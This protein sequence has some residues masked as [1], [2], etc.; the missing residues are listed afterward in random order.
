MQRRRIASLGADV[1]AAARSLWRRWDEDARPWLLGVL[2]LGL[3]FRALAA[4]SA[5]VS[6]D[7]PRTLLVARSLASG[8]GFRLCDLYFPACGPGHDLTAQV[9]PV[10][11]GVFAVV[12]RL[13]GEHLSLPLMVGIQMGLGILTVY[14]VFALGV[15]LFQ[16]TR[17]ALLAALLCATYP[18]LISYELYPREEPLFTAALVASTLLLVRALRDSAPVR[19]G[20]AGLGFG[21]ASLCRFALVYYP[22]ILTPGLLALTRGPGR[23]RAAV[24]LAF[25]ACFALVMLPWVWR[26]ERAFGAFVPG[27]TLSG[28]NLYRHNFI[29]GE[30]RPLHYVEGL[31]GDSAIRALLR[32]HPELTGRETEV[33]IDRLYRDEALTIIRAHP[34]RYLELSGRRLVALFTEYGVQPEGLP[35]SW[36]VV[37]AEH[38]LIVALA[39]ATLLRRRLS[40]PPALAAIALL[41]GYYVAG[42]ALA[43]ARLRYIV[44]VMPLFM[45]LA[46]AELDRLGSAALKPRRG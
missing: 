34:W 11:A 7:E 23:R 10:P 1:P 14:G 44:P 8:R 19:S 9:G 35:L 32:R 38:L 39:A 43:N 27:G 6:G 29:L 46:G 13:A 30:D 5:G 21:V 15:M 12:L 45:L 24:T 42:H 26:N 36:W 28:Y 17:P 22:L 18:H 41:L 37:N 33:Q 4:L 2:T 31:E 25:A 3:A 40:R 16:G 20:L